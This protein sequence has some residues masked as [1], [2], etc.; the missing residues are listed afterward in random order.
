V[1]A[2]PVDHPGALAD[3]LV[4]VVAQHPDLQRVLV[5]ER[6]REAV[7]PVSDARQRDRACVDR[8]RLPRLAG[9]LARLA[10]HRR[11]HPDHPFTGRDQRRLQARRDMPAVLDRPH[12]LR[13]LQ[14]GGEPQRLKRP[15]I[16]GR[17]LALALQLA[18]L[19]V[20]RDQRVVALVGVCPEHDHV[21][22]SLR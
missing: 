9:D 6:H 22:S 4:A 1:P 2:Q 13:V 17:D 8:I 16:A 12:P 3:D 10:G 21:P 7:A 14:A 20:H 5:G 15:F 18:G 11:R 19:S